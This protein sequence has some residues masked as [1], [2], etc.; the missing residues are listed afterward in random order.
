MI[1]IDFEFQT[2]YGVFRDAIHLPVD[3]QYS[4]EQIIEMQS[5]RLN[6]WLFALENPPAPKPDTIELNGVIYEKV[7]INGQVVLKPVGV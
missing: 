2:N 6:N 3:H 7:E 4:Q 5:E 1:K